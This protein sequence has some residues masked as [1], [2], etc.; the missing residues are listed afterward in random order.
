M[1]ILVRDGRIAVCS[2]P[3]NRLPRGACKPRAAC[4]SRLIDAHVHFGFGEKVTEYPPRR[5]R[6]TGRFRHVLG[7]LLNTGAYDEV[8]D[9]ELGYAK[10]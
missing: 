1:D 7:Y 9:R 2:R 6:G 4:I 5:L 3:A 10:A 8:F